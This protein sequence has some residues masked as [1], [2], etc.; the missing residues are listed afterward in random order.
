MPEAAQPA[1]ADLDATFQ[2]HMDWFAAVAKLC[3]SPT[4]VGGLLAGVGYFSPSSSSKIS[5]KS[6]RR[7]VAWPG[8]PSHVA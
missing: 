7:S 2:S 5:S 8:S 4:R 6:V 1:L 3:G